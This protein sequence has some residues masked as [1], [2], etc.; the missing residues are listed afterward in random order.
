M[1][2][3]KKNF[4]YP[5]LS[6]RLKKIQSIR[7]NRRSLKKI[8]ETF[9]SFYYYKKLNKLFFYFIKKIKDNFFIILLKK[10]FLL[11]YKKNQFKKIQHNQ[12][13]FE[14]QN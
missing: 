10:W 9:F 14:K 4:N 7:L 6:V 13:Q 1:I 5:K 2:V 3:L 8:K 11:F 12:A